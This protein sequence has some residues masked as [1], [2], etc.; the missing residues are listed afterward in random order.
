MV[1]VGTRGRVMGFEGGKGEGGAVQ[2]WYGEAFQG[3]W[4]W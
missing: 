2:D 1:L 3:I 4:R